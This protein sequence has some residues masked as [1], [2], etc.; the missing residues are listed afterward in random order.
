[1]ITMSLEN[2]NLNEEGIQ[3]MVDNTISE[4]DY[5][6]SID[7]NTCMYDDGHVGAIID[8]EIVGHEIGAVVDLTE[9]PTPR[10]GVFT[11]TID[12]GM[13]GTFHA[14]GR[15]KAGELEITNLDGGGSPLEDSV[16][17]MA[18]EFLS[19]GME[20]TEK[21]LHIDRI[22]DPD[23]SSIV[24]LTLGFNMYVR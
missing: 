14:I 18:N 1:M 13:L 12:A 10:Y 3:Q 15:L 11:G 23:K 2:E 7:T 9:K 20:E 5:D 19:M 8:T 22:N 16:K 24:N 4:M 6:F 21:E 17:A